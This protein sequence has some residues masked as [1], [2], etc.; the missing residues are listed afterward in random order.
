MRRALVLSGGGSRGAFQVGVIEHL[1]KSVSWDAVYGV[2]VGAIN[3]ALIAQYKKQDVQLAAQALRALWLGIHGNYSIYKNWSL[4]ILEFLFSRGGQY[5]T[6]PLLQL[7]R[8]N[9][10][11][12]AL[13]TSGVDLTV[14]AV[15]LTYGLWRTANK[16]FP[17]LEKWILASATFPGAFPP[18]MIDGDYYVDGGI[19]TVT[20][21]LTALGDRDVTHI[22]VIACGPK[23]GF[24]QSW[25]SSKVHSGVDV[26]LRCAEIM[27][28]EIFVDDMNISEHYKAGVEINVYTPKMPINTD[29]LNFSPNEIRKNMCAEFVCLRV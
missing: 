25:D 13:A 19:R 4:G 10:N 3:A 1:A 23:N 6:E 9:L 28:D 11:M 7:I 21:L 17:D 18:V 15:G 20:P 24:L 12:R 16:S 29:P 5:N 2:S 14:G 26:V 27:A 22:D 8:K